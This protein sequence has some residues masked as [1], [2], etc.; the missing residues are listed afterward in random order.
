[1]ALAAYVAENVI[2][3]LQWE[4]RPLSSV[5]CP[6]IGACQCGKMEMGKW[7]GEYPHRDRRRR[8]G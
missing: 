4:E 5:Q 2:V 6:S 1:M 3:G 8:M 7:V